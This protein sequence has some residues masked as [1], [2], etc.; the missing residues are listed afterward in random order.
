MPDVMH[1]TCGAF[2]WRL[3]LHLEHGMGSLSG[4]RI[5]PS[6]DGSMIPKAFTWMFAVF[7]FAVTGCFF[8]LGMIDSR[9]DWTSSVKL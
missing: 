9:L 5:A 8:P 1:V 2:S 7:A 3:P 6:I 4:L